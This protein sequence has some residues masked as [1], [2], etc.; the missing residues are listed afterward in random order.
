MTGVQ[1]CI[2]W[3][4][5][6]VSLTFTYIVTAFFLHQP[7]ALQENAENEDR[8]QTVVRLLLD[9]G[10]DINATSQPS[11]ET[12]VHLAGNP[13]FRVLIYALLT[14]V[15]MPA[16][17]GNKMLFTALMELGADINAVTTA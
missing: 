5:R 10:V 17:T 3:Q 8:L 11:G 13:L 14:L 4:H 6:L 9:E 2:T 7:K 15:P 1:S 12:C 16:L